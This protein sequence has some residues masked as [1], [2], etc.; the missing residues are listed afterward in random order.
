M[1]VGLTFVVLYFYKFALP[2]ISSINS[3]VLPIRPALFVLDNFL[4]PITSMEISG[5]R[6]YTLKTL[7]AGNQFALCLTRLDAYFFLQK[8]TWV[9]Q[10]L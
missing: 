7:K 9:T 2:S 10:I 1:S 8:S 6:S 3:R 4:W 5:I